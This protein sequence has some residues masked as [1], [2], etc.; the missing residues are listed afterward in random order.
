MAK[1]LHLA[2]REL[3]RLTGRCVPGITTSVCVLGIGPYQDGRHAEDGSARRGSSR[4]VQHR[5][6]NTPRG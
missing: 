6:S 3:N 5:A 2:L 1:I 4:M